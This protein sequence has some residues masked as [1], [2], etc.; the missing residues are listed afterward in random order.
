[1]TWTWTWPTSC[2]A[3]LPLFCRML[4]PAAPVAPLGEPDRR[5]AVAAWE[6]WGAPEIQLRVHDLFLARA[7]DL[8]PFREYAGCQAGDALGHLTAGGTVTACRTLPVRIGDLGDQGL[9]EIWAATPRRALRRELEQTPAACAGCAVAGRCGGGCRG[10]L[11]AGSATAD[12]GVPDP[13]CPGPLAGD[14]E[15]QG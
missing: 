6:H 7:L 8:A 13:S 10:L 14:E 3:I 1:M 15:G 12:L 2:P 4:Y 5:T 11:R 9:R